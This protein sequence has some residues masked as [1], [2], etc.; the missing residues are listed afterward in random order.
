MTGPVTDFSLSILRILRDDYRKLTHDQRQ[1][2]RVYA[3]RSWEEDGIMCFEVASY[4]IDEIMAAGEIKVES[5]I[6][7]NKMTKNHGS[8]VEVFGDGKVKAGEYESSAQ[9]FDT[10][11]AAYAYFR[12]MATGTSGHWAWHICYILEDYLSQRDEG[13]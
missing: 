2:L 6:L 8:Y 9:M 10:A 3:A 11:D 13:R 12:P 4:R 5:Q 1:R 7:L